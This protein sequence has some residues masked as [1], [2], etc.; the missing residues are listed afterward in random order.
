MTGGAQVRQIASALVRCGTDVLMVLQKGPEDPEAHW[1]LAGG[2]V[3]PG[4]LAAE[5][6]VR[7]V[8]EE[9][10]L[11]G[12][13]TPVMYKQLHYPAQTPK[14]RRS[15]AVSVARPRLQNCLTNR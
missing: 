6:L 9:A 2:V 11:E 8:R 1:A 13:S 4:K 3:E 12:L 15:W 7:E 14:P 10:G 5:A